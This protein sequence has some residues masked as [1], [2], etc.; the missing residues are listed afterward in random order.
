MLCLHFG[1]IHGKQKVVRFA[2]ICRIAMFVILLNSVVFCHCCCISLTLPCM[3][4]ARLFI[5]VRMCKRSCTPL[6]FVALSFGIAFHWH[7]IYPI[8]TCFSSVLYYLFIWAFFSLPFACYTAFCILL[9][10]IP[11]LNSRIKK[12][13]PNAKA[14]TMLMDVSLSYVQTQY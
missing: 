8:A 6:V 9:T 14:S 3:C 2:F 13:C 12:I 11:V 10:K 4:W 7:D 5:D 1:K